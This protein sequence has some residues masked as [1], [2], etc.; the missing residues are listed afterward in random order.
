V[1]D[2]VIRLLATFTLTWTNPTLTA[3]VPAV[4]DSTAIECTGY[5][6]LSDLDHIDLHI[7][8]RWRSDSVVTIPATGR[9]GLSESYTIVTDKILSIWLV[10]VDHTG[11]AGCAS[12]RVTLNIPSTS[13]DGPRGRAK[14]IW[15]DI[16][17]RIIDE[18]R[19]PGI[20]FRKDGKIKRVIIR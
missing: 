19:M 13:V 16:A 2:L 10:P 9:E 12:R 8:E 15:Y 11:N 5:L 18:P 1:Y 3:Y 14:V 20:Y 17:G 7:I 6:P 4:G